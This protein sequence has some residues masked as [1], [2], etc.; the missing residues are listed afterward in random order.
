M[1]GGIAP[2]IAPSPRTDRP[3]PAVR[4]PRLHPLPARPARPPAV[5]RAGRQPARPRPPPPAPAIAPRIPTLLPIRPIPPAPPHPPAPSPRAVQSPEALPRR[6]A[7]IPQ[8]C[9]CRTTPPAPNGLTTS[10]MG[11]PLKHMTLPP[12]VSPALRRRSRRT[13]SDMTGGPA[14][15]Q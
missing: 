1:S 4:R 14:A 7:C 5:Q 3:R 11:C 9:R 12:P 15:V 13:T 8:P 6:T 10:L 2:P